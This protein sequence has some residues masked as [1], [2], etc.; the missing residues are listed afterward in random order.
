[1]SKPLIDEDGEVGE[2]TEENFF[3]KAVRGRPPMLPGD[4]KI[5]TTIMLDPDVVAHFKS[6]GAGGRHV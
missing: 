6:E 2:L 4:R 5:K 1:M 3:N